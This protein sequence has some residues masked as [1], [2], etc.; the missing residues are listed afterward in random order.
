MMLEV[1]PL[2]YLRNWDVRSKMNRDERFN[3][4]ARTFQWVRTYVSMGSHVR[5]NGFARTFKRI[6]VRLKCYHVRLGGGTF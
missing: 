5:F 1:G 4:L 3:G 2:T 6:H